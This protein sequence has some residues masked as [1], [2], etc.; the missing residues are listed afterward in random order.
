MQIKKTMK[1]VFLFVS[2]NN[3]LL[4]GSRRDRKYCSAFCKYSLIAATFWAH[5]GLFHLCCFM[6]RG[7]KI[8]NTLLTC[9]TNSSVLW[10]CSSFLIPRA[11]HSARA[12]A[13]NA[14]N[15]C[16]AS[17]TFIGWDFHSICCCLIL[18]A[19]CKP[20]L[21]WISSLKLGNVSIVQILGC[22]SLVNLH[23]T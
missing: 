9:L 14:L 6:L 4:K 17:D 5:K 22:D 12:S 8:S 21:Y 20:S 11:L 1:P 15:N 16:A 7:F 19:K 10:G 13:T 2:I 23:Q 18:F 3:L